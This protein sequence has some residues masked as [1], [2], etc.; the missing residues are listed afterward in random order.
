MVIRD[1]SAV[2]EG[3]LVD[4]KGSMRLG[5]GAY[6]GAYTRASRFENGPGTNPEELIGA[7]HAGCFSMFLAAILSKAGHTVEQIN[8]TARVHLGDGPKI[9]LIELSTTGV[10]PGI[11]EATFIEFAEQAKKSCP[12]SQALASVEMKLTASL[13]Q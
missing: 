5:S 1:S 8:T 9:T 12:V 7:A 13:S 6:E 11:D 4:G 2:W 10:V 3:N